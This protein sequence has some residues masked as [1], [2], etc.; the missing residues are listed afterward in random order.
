M[1]LINESKKTDVSRRLRDK[2]QYD[3]QY[4]DTILNI[5]P[6]NSKYIDYIAKTLEEL[7]LMLAGQRGGLT[8]L[9]G[10]TLIG[11]FNDVIPWFETNS[12]RITPEFLKK[13]RDQYIRDMEND[14]PNFESILKSPKDINQYHPY[15]IQTLKAIVNESKTKKEL[16]KEIKDQ[17]DKLYEDDNYLV[18]KPNTYEA[19]CYYGAGTK[20][21]TTT[22]D[23]RSYFDKYKKTGNLYYFIDKKNN[24]NKIAVYKEPHKSEIYDS[25]DEQ[26]SLNKLRNS[27]P[28]EITDEIIGVGNVYKE[29]RKFAKGNNTKNDVFESDPNIFSIK[30]ES[31]LGQSIVIIDF[32]NDDNFFDA[33]DLGDDD[34]YFIAQIDNQGGY[35]YIV[36]DSYQ[37]FE[38][39][40]DGYNFYDDLD[41]NNISKLETISTLLAIDGFDLKSESFR[42]KLSK[43]LLNMFDKE[44]SEMVYE[45]ISQTDNMAV[46]S[47]SEQIEKE[48]NNFLKKNGFEIN[49]KYDLIQTTVANLV[50][51][52]IRLNKENLDILSLIPLIFEDSNLGGWSEDRYQFSDPENFDRVSFNNSVSYSLEQILSKI[53]EQY[54]GKEEYL[55][56]FLEM[57]EKISSLYERDSWYPL[58][59]DKDISFKIIG[60]D[61]SDMK[62]KLKI[63]TPNNFPVNTKL[64]EENFYH[65]LYQPELFKFGEV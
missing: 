9:Q 31:P 25:K 56:N 1:N 45:W 52:F 41:E 28:L 29:L 18:I 39:F 34:K 24:S 38:D 4:I 20:W 6:T 3:G 47:A 51:W 60:F 63:T 11:V 64:S 44:T 42:S 33:L 23:D 17:A 8:A 59:K 32:E 10:R 15:F 46:S 57:V 2:F 37:S 35:D 19:S 22:K 53:E 49:R 12:N 14:V 7:I 61:I 62:I 26:I 65:L 58:P 48:I 43:T 21:C 54:E 30:T 16:E 40:K 36:Y 5:D 50:Y 13:A 27:F 55:Q